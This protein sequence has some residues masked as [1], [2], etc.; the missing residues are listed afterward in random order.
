MIKVIV[1]GDGWLRKSNRQISKAAIVELAIL[2]A[3][4]AVIIGGDG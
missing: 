4:I 2:A 1:G 3:T